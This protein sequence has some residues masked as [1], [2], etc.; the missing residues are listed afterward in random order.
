MRRS[1]AQRAAGGGSRRPCGRTPCA[2]C[3]LQR[4]TCLAPT[5]RDTETAHQP[6]RGAVREKTLVSRGATSR[7]HDTWPESRGQVF[8]PCGVLNLVDELWEERPA[9]RVALA[10]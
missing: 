7:R 9:R 4:R 10:P 5:R 3:E 1:P 2:G 6:E 8:R